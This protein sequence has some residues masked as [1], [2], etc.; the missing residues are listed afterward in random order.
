MFIED[1]AKKVLEEDIGRGDLFEKIAKPVDAKAK[2]VAKSN[3]VLAGVKYA[4]AIISYLGLKVNWLKS[5][6]DDFK[7]G[8]LIALIEGK[9][10]DIL[11]SERAIL[12]TILHASSIATNTNKFV[13]KLKNSDV[14]ILDTRKTRP[15]LRE[16]EKYAVLCGG[17]V[18]H[19]LGLDDCLML[20]DTHLKTIKNLKEF[21]KEARKK[22]PFTSKIE[23]ECESFMKAKEAME[24][25]ADIVMCDNMEI[26]EIKRVVNLKDEN[27]P[28]ILIEVSGNVTLENIEKYLNLGIDAISSGSLVH[29]A[30]WPDL[31]MKIES[32]DV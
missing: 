25:G 19:R 21:L 18:N 12:N 20:K 4:N 3:G 32:A 26:D 23:I 29:H 24:A 7:K 30:V 6:G 11:K 16:F 27:F 1:F 9:S 8:D 14:K 28:H 10:I 22:I 15:L 17:G 5:D 31:S 2:I 13:Q